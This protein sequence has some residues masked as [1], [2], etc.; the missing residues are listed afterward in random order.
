MAPH[1]HEPSKAKRSS[2]GVRSL[3][4]GALDRRRRTCA[5]GRLDLNC[6]SGLYLDATDVGRIARVA[7][8]Y[9]VD[10]LPQL[11]RD[12]AGRVWRQSG[13]ERI[14]SRKD[15][16]CR[17]ADA[18][19]GAGGEDGRDEF[20]RVPGPSELHNRERRSSDGRNPRQSGHDGL[21]A[22]KRYAS[23]EAA[24]SCPGSFGARRQRRC[25]GFLSRRMRSNGAH[26]RVVLARTYRLASTSGPAPASS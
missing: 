2:N 20:P 15:F 6:L 25:R 21:N 10:A 8:A 5:Q 26:Q 19:V 11:L 17:I 4:H 1:P 18:S 9:H 24:D 12:P 13:D 16:N 7:D 14:L 3:A 23:H 22:R